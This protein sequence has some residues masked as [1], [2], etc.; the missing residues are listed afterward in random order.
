LREAHIRDL[1]GAL[2][3]A[4]RESGGDFT[5]NPPPETVL[6]AGQILIAIGTE[7]Q[8]KGLTDAARA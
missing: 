2:V 4:L 8:L 5:M 1:T 3:L 6:R 7:G